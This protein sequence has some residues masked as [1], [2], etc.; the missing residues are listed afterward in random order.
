[1]RI[2]IHGE[3]S[4]DGLPRV[5]AV[6]KCPELNISYPIIFI[7]DTGTTNSSIHD[8]DVERLGINYNN[9]VL[10]DKNKIGIGG[11]ELTT[12]KLPNSKLIFTTGKDR[13]FSEELENG[14]VLKHEF[15]SEKQRRD[16]F[17][18]SSLLG[19]DIL[20]KYTIR[21]NNFTVFLEL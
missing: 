16:I 14:L 6:L 1:M 21:F 2:S 20:K 9:L 15:T 10:A 19:M 8:K 3:I 13:E 18:F 11:G 7:I 17:T 12:Y 5:E 4:P